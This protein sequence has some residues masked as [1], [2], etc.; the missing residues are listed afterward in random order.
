MKQTIYVELSDYKISI[1]RN[2][3]ERIITLYRGSWNWIGLEDWIRKTN[4]KPQCEL[5][6]NCDGIVRLED[7]ECDFTDLDLQVP[8]EK[9]MET[10]YKKYSTDYT[11]WYGRNLKDMVAP[12]V[13]P[14][15]DT[16]GYRF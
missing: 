14:D 7:W 11:R 13:K 1:I 6:E 8:D 3:Y 16:Y 12:L 10:L 9:Y 4:I 5:Y 2:P 15:L